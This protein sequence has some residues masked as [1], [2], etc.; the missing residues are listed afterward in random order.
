MKTKKN[1]VTVV[2]DIKT[3]KEEKNMK[4]FMTLILAVAMLITSV[5]VAPSA[6]KAATTYSVTRSYSNPVNKSGTATFEYVNGEV[7]YSNSKLTKYQLTQTDV[8]ACSSETDQE[9]CQFFDKWGTLWVVYR[10]EGLYWYNYEI[11]KKGKLQKW[12][13]ISDSEKI[14]ATRLCYD[15][16]ESTTTI[17]D[18]GSLKYTGFTYVNYYTSG[19]NL[20]DYPLPDWYTLYRIINDED[21]PTVEPTVAPTTE[22]TVTPTVEPTVAPT[23]EP[24]VTPTVAPTEAP[25]TEPTVAPTPTCQCG[26]G[27]KCTCPDG[28]CKCKDCK[29]SPEAPCHTA[30][31]APVETPSNCN[32]A[33]NNGESGDAIVDNGSNG[34]ANTGKNGGNGNNAISI[35]GDGNTVVIVNPVVVHDNDTKNDSDIDVNGDNNNVSDKLNGGEQ[36]GN[37]VADTTG[38]GNVE[39]T[40]Q[41]SA[42]LTP[43]VPLI[44]VSTPST[45]SSVEKATTSS[46]KKKVHYT[47]KHTKN[48]VQLI[49]HSGDGTCGAIHKVRFL[50]KKHVCWINNK[51]YTKVYRVGYTK[52]SRQITVFYGGKKGARKIKIVQRGSNQKNWKNRVL[53]GKYAGI[54]AGSHGLDLRANTKAGKSINLQNKKAIKL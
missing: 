9:I 40:A 28:Q 4:K 24:T 44:N 36:T 34:N 25:T 41:S 18:A 38:N 22:P 12:A 13:G 32:P 16:N 49:K 17:Y 47:V 14:Y 42:G 48:Y 23:T 31:A 2:K 27:G 46:K 19:K 39:A 37:N 53:K 3:F 51:K 8:A 15:V 26:N 1:N 30:T 33:D 45:V 29:C 54:S 20:N 5:S 7:Y 50:R 52:K 10:N 35:D 21:Y 6:A 11:L 43:E